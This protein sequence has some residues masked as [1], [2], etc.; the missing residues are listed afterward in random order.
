MADV[1]AYKAMW[2]WLRTF[3]ARALVTG[4]EWRCTVRPPLPYTVSFVV[5]LAEVVQ[6]ERVTARVSG[7]IAGTAELT[8]HGVA[9]ACEVVVRSDLQ[10]RSG[11]LKVLANTLPPVARFGHDWI[12]STGA[13]PFERRAFGVTYDARDTTT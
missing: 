8:L 1:H 5:T 12:L 7:D 6:D 10:P 3:D 11:F 9:G 2:P 13:A 4:D